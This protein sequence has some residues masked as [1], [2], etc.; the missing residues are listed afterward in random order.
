MDVEDWTA[1]G[2]ISAAM[3]AVAAW[4]LYRKTRAR[5]LPVIS[6]RWVSVEP[7]DE[8]RQIR[9]EFDSLDER[10]W[11]IE[12]ARIAGWRCHRIAENTGA[13][14]SNHGEFLW[15]ITGPW[16]RSVHFDPPV[17]EGQIAAHPNTPDSIWIRFTIR[18]RVSR[19]SRGSVVVRVTAAT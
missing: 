14:R 11:Q 5:D 1:L 7:P 13:E 19:W 18:S 17:M 6:A 9:F 12:G 8:S 16:L 10:R 15:Y 2:A 3:A 4:L